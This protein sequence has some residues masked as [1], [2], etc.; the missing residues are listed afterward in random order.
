MNGAEVQ[1]RLLLEF[2]A[3]L[4]GFF[5]GGS[6]HLDGDAVVALSLDGE[7]FGVVGIEAL[8]DNVDDGLLIL[9]A[10]RKRSGGGGINLR[11]NTDS[12]RRTAGEVDARLETFTPNGQ[13]TQ[14]DHNQSRDG[15]D[16]AFVSILLGR[17]VGEEQAKDE[18]ANEEDN[19]CLLYTSPSPRDQ[20]GSRMPSSA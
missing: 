15:A 17:E 6:W 20:R 7:V 8:R 12:E 3:N 9:G 2:D 11:V 16:V 14:A 18:K 1:D 5:L 4:I 19:I 13:A 10:D